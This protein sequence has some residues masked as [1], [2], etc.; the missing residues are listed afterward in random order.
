MTVHDE[1]KNN[2]TLVVCAIGSRKTYLMLKILSRIC[3]KDIYKLTKS[4]P[5]EYFIS[6]TE[7]RG[8]GDKIKHLSE[9][10]GGIVV[11]DDF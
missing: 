11:L 5:D 3:D 8:I 1:L 9:Y 4:P 7:I 2:R 10:G 6:K